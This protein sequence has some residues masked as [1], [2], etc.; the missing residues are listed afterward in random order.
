MKGKT[1]PAFFFLCLIIL[2]A[3]AG[4]KNILFRPGQEDNSFSEPERSL[5]L[6]D[7]IEAK[8]GVEKTDL[9]EWL[10]AFGNGGIDEV[11]RMDFYRGRYC[12]IVK[13][14]GKN[15]DALKKWAENYSA[16]QDFSRLAAARIEKRL[17]SA[18]SLYPDDEYGVFF[19]RLIKRA[20]SA[21]YPGAV[22]EDTH[23]I[24]AGEGFEFFILISI[25]FES[26]QEAVGDMIADVYVSVTPT[27]AQRAAIN[28]L[29]Q[30][31]FEGF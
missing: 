29:Q 8:D 20:F 13:N 5:A 21:E 12:F 28:R 25:D 10:L 15:F 22:K 9:P 23:W 3:C 11:E 17:I 16:A 7:I 6:N 31:F 1:F 26:M 19:E 4:Q 18:A 2:S 24:R 27:R 14:E 30:N